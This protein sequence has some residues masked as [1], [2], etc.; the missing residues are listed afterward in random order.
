GIR[1][2]TMSPDETTADLG[3]VYDESYRGPGL[4][5]AEVLKRGP[6]DKRGL[7]VKVGDI[8]LSVD[9]TDLTDK[10]EVSRLLNDKVGQPVALVASANR[11]APKAR[12]RVEVQA[13]DRRQVSELMYERWADHN[14]RRVAEMTGGK[15]GY[16]HIPNMEEGG[17]DRFVRA[18]Y[19][20]NFDKE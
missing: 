1:G 12:R 9:G 14:A 18:L 5:V 15:V 17:L 10:V 3:L 8:I 4:K 7:D 19:S 16:I 13:A 11:A 20:D 6:A 2:F